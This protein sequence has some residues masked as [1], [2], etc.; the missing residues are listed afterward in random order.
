LKKKITADLTSLAHRILQ[1]KKKE[2]INELL[3][4]SRELHERLTVLAYVQNHFAD[5]EPTAGLAQ[6][7]QR[8]DEITNADPENFEQGAQNA[9]RSSNLSSLYISADQDEREDMD[10]P[11]ISTIQKMV[12]EMPDDQKEEK[13]ALDE[14]L[15]E[16]AIEDRFNKNDMENIAADYQTMPVFE[17]KQ[18]GADNV[19]QADANKR[20]EKTANQINTS[21]DDDI[22]KRIA[23]LEDFSFSEDTFTRKE[24]K[25]DDVQAKDFKQNLNDP[26]QSMMNFDSAESEDK[27]KSLN[28]RLNRGIKIGMNDRIGFI[29]HLFNGNDAEFNRV[30]SQLS[31]IE[32]VDEARHFIDSLVKP[33]YNNWEGK[34]TYETRF[35]EIVERSY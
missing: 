1:F 28:D 13:G 35:M 7:E 14:V 5:M 12:E 2:D 3:N 8:L 15:Q 34:E 18:S 27:P 31:T 16:N 24:S 9:F 10:L 21:G 33:D 32:R 26:Q 4:L 20:D 23:A 19:D 17:R 25:D 11:G 6:I 30:V 22:K 29:K